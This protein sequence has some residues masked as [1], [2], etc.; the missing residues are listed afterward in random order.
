MTI[1]FRIGLINISRHNLVP[2]VSGGTRNEVVPKVD[3]Q[4]RSRPF[5]AFLVSTFAELQI[6]H[7]RIEKST[8]Y[9]VLN[10]FNKDI[11]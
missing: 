2:R 6:T 11:T 10:L 1:H 8:I 7:E 4:P 9:Q 3:L 5:C